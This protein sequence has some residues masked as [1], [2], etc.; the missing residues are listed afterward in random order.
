MRNKVWLLNKISV[1]ADARPGTTVTLKAHASYLVC[2]NICIPQEQALAVTLKIG[3]G[4]AD[5]AA[6][7]DFAAARALLPTDSPWP[8]QFAVQKQTCPGKA[9]PDTGKREAAPCLD[10]YL[11]APALAAAHA[12]TVD[13]FP[14]DS[15]LVVGDAPQHTG[16]TRDGLVLRAAAGTKATAAKTLAG[17]LVLT[18]SDGTVQA[19]NVKASP[20]TV[21]IAGFCRARSRRRRGGAGRAAAV[22]DDAVRAPWV[23]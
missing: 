19:L 18:G 11:A 17:V 9:D 21:P 4:G 16:F 23:G 7:K 6:V 5:A 12:K 3:A 1:P 2:Q 22:A 13:F 14:L 20:G 10:L 8:L 15:G